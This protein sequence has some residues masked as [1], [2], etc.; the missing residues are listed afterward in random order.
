MSWTVVES[1]RG[2]KSSSCTHPP[3]GEAMASV[4]KSRGSRLRLALG[5]RFAIE[6][7]SQ[8]TRTAES[9]SRRLTLH[10]DLGRLGYQGQ[11]LLP[12]R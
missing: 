10:E 2:T 9:H 11:S 7:M 12:M 5:T 8:R 1:G 6:L 3:N 4:H